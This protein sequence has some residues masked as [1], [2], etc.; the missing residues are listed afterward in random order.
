VIGA[1][2]NVGGR[3][4]VVEQSSGSG[5][6]AGFLPTESDHPDPVFEVTG[7]A[8]AEILRR[9]REIRGSDGSFAGRLSF[10]RAVSRMRTPAHQGRRLLDFADVG[11]A[12]FVRD[13]HRVLLG[14]SASPADLDR[15]LRELGAGSS[16]ME[17]VVRLALCPEGRRARRPPVRGVGLP[18]LAVTG[19]AIEVLKGNPLVGPVAGRG[20]RIA[21][22]ILARRTSSRSTLLF[23]GGVVL[24][25][26]AVA[27][28]RLRS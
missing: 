23:A 19:A 5:A 2:R 9:C 26:V 6:G 8:A 10:Q 1:G 20:E 4:D 14:R 12:D 25:T 15:R 27:A 24:V 18:A 11:D 16:R 7:I 13:A 21:R 22:S 17:I 28:R 3:Y